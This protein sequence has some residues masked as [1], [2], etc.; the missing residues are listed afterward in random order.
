MSDR[1]ALC[2]MGGRELARRVRA[3]EVSPVEVVEAHL[4]RIGRIEPRLH[5]YL[6]VAAEHAREA[7]R[8]AEAAVR[9]GEPLG[10]LHGVPCSL[11]DLTPTRGI[12]TT[13]G[14]K[15]YE[16]HVPAEDA[17]L[18]ERL[19]AAG[20][21]VLGK[22]NTPEFGCKPFTDNQVAP[23]T[24]NPWSLSRSPGGSS[25]GAAAAVAAG[26]GPLAE[27]SDL[28]GS[29]RHPAAWCGVVGFKPSQ[30]RIP[31]YPT[32][33]AWNAMSV[34]GPITRTVADAALMFAAMAG[35][36]PRDPL[37]L[38]PTGEDW[39]RVT[40]APGPRGLRVAWTPDL[41][42]AAAVDPEVVA[43][44][45]AAARRLGS[46]G[47]TV[48][49]AS[50][51]VGPILEPFLALNAV[52]R[53]AAVGPYLDEWRAEMDPVLVKRL[54]LGRSLTAADV[55]RAEAARTAYHHRL[56][57]FFES[58][59]LLCCPTTATAALPLGGPIPA[60]VGGRPVTQPVDM[61]MPTLAF[62][63][64]GYPAISV[65][66]GVTA[67]GLPVGLQLV[68]GWRADARVLAAAAAF[69]A[70]FPWAERRPPL[71]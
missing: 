17:L 31:R 40:D 35:P 33:T 8:A 48:T 16:H 7:A 38:P 13:M 12:R 57:R 54:E 49:E 41:G 18:V 19:R 68:A 5:A 43:V 67:E 45:E 39:A 23:P 9:R 26:L 6:T 69:E 63:L 60:V 27:G 58:H 65:P 1:D 66:C 70:A 10:P 56:R 15:I 37:A 64:S 32:A 71:D 46:L 11:K 4:D 42:G 47:W 62:N 21:I 34:H 24:A 51:D 55:S 61:L 36:D 29:I 30:G 3:K 2:W 52:L 53:Q 28:A 50:P 44:C 22:T 14:S 20:A 59:D 25:G